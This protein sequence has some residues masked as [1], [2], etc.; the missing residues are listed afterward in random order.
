MKQQFFTFLHQYAGRPPHLGS[1][2]DNNQ[3]SF[4]HDG[5]DDAAADT[6]RAVFSTAKLALAH[7]IHTGGGN[8]DNI[9]SNKTLAR[10]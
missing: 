1:I 7:M 9:F 3:V 4:R 5:K 10:S 6:A 8:W 2:Y